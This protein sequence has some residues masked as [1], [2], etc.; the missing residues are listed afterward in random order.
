MRNLKI[1]VADEQPVVRQ[2]IRHLVEARPQWD[3]CGEA[4]NGDE[5]LAVAFDTLPDVAVMAVSL[6]GSNGITVTRRIVEAGLETRVL[7]YSNHNDDKTI[8]DGLA[9][10]ARG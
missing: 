5:A 6:P 3:V 1:L 4:G 10:G 9:A 7:L 8:A 2:G